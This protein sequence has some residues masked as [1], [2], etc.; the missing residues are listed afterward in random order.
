MNTSAANRRVNWVAIAALVMPIMAAAAPTTDL[1]REVLGRKLVQ[2]A[3]ESFDLQERD[4]QLRV[5][6][7]PN[8]QDNGWKNREWIV[9][10]RSQ[11]TDVGN[12]TYWLVARQGALVH[13]EYPVTVDLSVTVNAF[14]TTGIVSRFVST[15]EI[16]CVSQP[17]RITH[18]FR[19]IIRSKN[20]L[21][22]KVTCQ[23]IPSGR[24]LTR[25]MLMD[26]PDVMKGDKVKVSVRT[27]DLVISADGITTE[28]G[29]VGDK[30]RVYCTTTR[31][32]LVGTVQDP[33]TV[34]IE[35]Q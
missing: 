1:M 28:S 5:R 10:N 14:V 17:T 16:P 18:D 9:E 11:S 31:V 6:Q 24:V 21:K 19:Q 22:G 25:D 7:W 26:P 2:Y 35:V 32:Y 34:V 33:N 8:I 23:V 15:K 13:D 27:G 20:D 12:Q 4:I 29:A 30:I 3:A